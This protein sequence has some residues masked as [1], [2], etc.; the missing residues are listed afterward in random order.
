MAF[1]QIRSVEGFFSGVKG[2]VR[3]LGLGIFVEIASALMWVL[4]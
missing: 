2:T 3:L 1:L 4:L